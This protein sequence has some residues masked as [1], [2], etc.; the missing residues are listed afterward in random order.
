MIII[1]Q[2]FFFFLEC[3]RSDLL[4]PFNNYLVIRLLKTPG[5]GGLWDM[6]E[7]NKSCLFPQSYLFQVIPALI[8][9]LLGKIKV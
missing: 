4:T 3:F 6:C 2:I 9:K 8:I 5:E 1:D 7:N